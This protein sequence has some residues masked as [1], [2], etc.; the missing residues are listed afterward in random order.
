VNQIDLV[1][2]VLHEIG[3]GL[4]FA[5]IVDLASGQKGLGTG[6]DDAFMLFLE[7]HSTNESY[8]DMTN[9]ERV[10]ASKDNGDLHWEGPAVVAGSTGLAS[11][12]HSPSGH[13][14]MFAPNPQQPG[15]SVSH[16]DTALAPNEIME[17]QYT[18]PIHD[19][20]LMRELFEDIGWD[21]L[22]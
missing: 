12:R 5:T 22:P 13:V 7:D 20:G 6:F 4:G 10:T 16:W 15:S 1:S 17:P 2:V 8:P 3:H 11:G 21:T 19:V 9:A 14:R 18:E